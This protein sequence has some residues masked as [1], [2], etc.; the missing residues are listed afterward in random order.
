[1]G[2]A[3]DR[4]ANGMEDAVHLDGQ[5][6]AALDASQRLQRGIVSH[7]V[8]QLSPGCTPADVW[9]IEL[10]QL[11]AAISMSQFVHRD[12]FDWSYLMAKLRKNCEKNKAFQ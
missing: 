6:G 7:N 8:F 11:H 3:S 5:E 12:M 10:C 1:M 4:A 9:E 2:L